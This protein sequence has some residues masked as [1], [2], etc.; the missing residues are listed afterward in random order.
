MENVMIDESYSFSLRQF[1]RQN[2]KAD[3]AQFDL[4][5]MSNVSEIECADI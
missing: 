4:S 2:S 5:K 3:L 1:D